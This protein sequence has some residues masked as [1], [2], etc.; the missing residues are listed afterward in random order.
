MRALLLSLMCL[1]G[2]KG[3]RGRRFL[4]NVPRTV[5]SSSSSSSSLP[6]QPSP[7][8]DD[9]DTFL[10]GQ[11]RTSFAAC[12]VHDDVA[13]ALL[14]CGKAFASTIQLKAFSAILSGEDTVVG[15]ETGS[16]KTLSYLVPIIHRLVEMRRAADPDTDAD[17]DADGTDCRWRRYPFAVVMCPNKELAAQVHRMVNDLTAELNVLLMTQGGDAAAPIAAGLFT[18]QLEQWPYFTEAD[19][20]P[21]IAIC[22]PAFLSKF[23]KGPN[24]QDPDLFRSVRVLVLDEV[25][26]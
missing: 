14:K 3:L 17:A 9:R 25:R 10:F 21:D 20:S 4:V 6:Q 7:P 2:G 26:E 15:S 24:I 8:L 23:I 12:G 13:A 16:G 18:Q 1:G 5:A 11:E 19:P 22:T